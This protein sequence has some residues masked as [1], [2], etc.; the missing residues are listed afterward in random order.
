MDVPRRDS[1]IFYSAA[2]V[3]ELH[4][5]SWGLTKEGEYEG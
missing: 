5:S 2:T 1:Y 3:T 4:P